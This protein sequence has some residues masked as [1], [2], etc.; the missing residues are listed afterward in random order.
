MPLLVSPPIVMCALGWTPAVADA[1]AEAGAALPV[2]SSRLNESTSSDPFA[3]WPADCSAAACA[4][5][6][7]CSDWN[8][9]CCAAGSMFASVRSNGLGMPGFCEAVSI[10]PG[11]PEAAGFSG[12]SSPWSSSGLMGLSS[13]GSL[14]RSS[15][16]SSLTSCGGG[17]E[18]AW[19]AALRRRASESSASG[20][21]GSGGEAGGEAR[22]TCFF[23]RAGACG[24]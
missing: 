3:L 13:D 24:G 23:V 16:E 12:A 15:A 14:A 10:L 17:R 1:P 6:L 7:V 22:R 8:T 19:R 5:E 11:Y 4:D 9:F 18:A 2:M 21:D 20:L